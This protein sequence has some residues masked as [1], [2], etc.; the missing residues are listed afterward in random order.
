MTL[1]SNLPNLNMIK[2]IL[3]ELGEVPLLCRLLTFSKDF[4]LSILSK[5][6]NEVL[7]LYIAQG[8]RVKRILVRK[9]R[10]DEVHAYRKPLK[11]WKCCNK[12][13]PFHVMNCELCG[14]CRPH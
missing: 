4:K 11:D 3:R 5:S 13:I 7:E 9:A 8:D 12:T 2:R 6:K 14:R 10:E 1:R